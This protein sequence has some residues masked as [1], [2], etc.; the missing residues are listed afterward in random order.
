[1]KNR[2]TF[3]DVTKALGIISIV[4]GHCHPD[5]RVV[6]FVYSY[7]LAIFFFVSGLQF[8]INKYSS[9]PFLLL[10]KRAQ[11][12]WPSFFGYL[13]FF[14]LTYNVS[15][16]LKLLPGGWNYSKFDL[17]NRTLNNFL[18]RGSET[19]GGAMWFVPVMLGSL[20]IFGAVI[21]FAHTYFYKYSMPATIICSCVIGVIGIYCNLL[22]KSLSSHLHTALLLMPLM[23]LGAMLSYYHI[24]YNKVF[25]LIPAIA[26]LAFTCYI[27]LGK[28][29]LIN[30]AAEDIGS[31]LLF[32]PLSLCGIY[33]MCTFAKYIDKAKP[34]SKALA[35]VGRYSFDIMALHFLTFK[36]IDL[37]YANL[38]GA[39]S[40][41][42]FPYAFSKLWPIYT[43]V[44]IC[45]I[46]WLRVGMSKLYS[47]S[48]KLAQK[49]FGSA[50]DDRTK[51]PIR[52]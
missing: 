6:R 45:L 14:T 18:F 37:C 20:L 11:T 28:G 33:A 49:C 10:Q 41:S 47:G 34:L 4:I 13:T 35:F 25:R 9:N 46:P 32:Y 39:E 22:G 44:S 27:T 26:C 1:M 36:I 5:I 17:L 31:A 51:E 16:K 29:V 23:L 43:I 50:V 24:D 48:K 30:L 12:M 3:Y 42:N 19:L 15:L 52:K 40:F 38:T 8:D 7:H 21:W 2:V